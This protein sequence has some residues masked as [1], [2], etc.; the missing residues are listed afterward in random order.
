MTGNPLYTFCMKQKNTLLAY[1]ALNN[2]KKYIIE[3]TNFC[4]HSVRN[5]CNYICICCKGN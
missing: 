3:K 4:N 5:N 2:W 1:Y